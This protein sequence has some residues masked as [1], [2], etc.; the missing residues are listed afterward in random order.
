MT[1]IGLRSICAHYQGDA[2]PP[3]YLRT[4]APATLAE[5]HSRAA[6]FVRCSVSW[7]G[8][9]AGGAHSDGAAG[10]RLR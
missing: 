3:V 9:C 4:D 6:V 7:G 8:G 1:D 5:F 2:N 10:G